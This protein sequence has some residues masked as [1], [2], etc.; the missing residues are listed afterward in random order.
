MHEA[1]DREVD[2]IFANTNGLLLIG[3]GAPV[4]SAAR[5]FFANAV[6]AA[7][8]GDA[9][10]IWGTCLGF[11]WLMQMAAEEDGVLHDGFDS[12]DLPLPLDLTPAAAGSRHFAFSTVL[13]TTRGTQDQGHTDTRLFIRY[14]R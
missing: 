3:G 4:C 2:A 7:R 8:A 11:E 6:S 1:T 13:L 14:T 5:R 10:P 12:E 9:Y